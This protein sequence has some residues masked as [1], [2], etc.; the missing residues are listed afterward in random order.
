MAHA[1]SGA[2]AVVPESL[3]TLTALIG[4]VVDLRHAADLIEWDERV[5]MPPASAQAHGDMSA[6]L[7]RVAHEKFTCDEVGR[8]LDA[9]RSEIDDRNRDTDL[10]RLVSV[11][12]HDYVKATRVP[13]DYVAAHAQVTSAAQNAWAEARAKSDFAM[14]QPHL[15]RVV[16][17]KRQYVTFFPPADHPYDALLDDYEPGMKTADVRRVFGALRPRQ[18]ALIRAIAERPQIDDSF[19]RG[20]YTEKELW[21]FA[22]EVITAFGFDWERGRQDKSAHPFATGVGPDDVRITTRWV[23]GQPLSLPFGTMHET[24]HALYEQGVGRTWHRTLLEGGASLGV[25]ES[26]S[27]LWENLVGRSRPFWERFFPVLQ[28]RFPSILGG[29]DTNAF[30]RAVNKVQPSLI[31]VE[32]DE[33]TYNLH[34]MLRVEIELGLIEGTMEVRD[35]PDIWNARMK[36]YLGLT[37]PDAAR[38]VLQDIHWSAGLFGYFATYTLGNIISAQLWEAFARAHPS[39]DDDIR[40]GDFSALLGWLRRNLHQYGRKFQ[41]QELVTRITGTAVDSEAYLRYLERKFGEIYGLP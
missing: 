22:V 36:E 14:F 34:V 4:E 18:V 23:P 38:G 31:R 9:L 20:A 15:E 11:T 8:T 39:R 27:R 30:Y 35:L 32:A 41:P 33:A 2:P 28:S 24:G 6:T 10:Y 26:Q 19:L 1:E 25:H 17:L 3:A 40:R 21:E 37:P 5:Y 13:A 12:A 29:V 7:R 16:E